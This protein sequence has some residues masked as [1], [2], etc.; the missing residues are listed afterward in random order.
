MRTEVDYSKGKK[1]IENFV[2]D[3]FRSPT[4]KEFKNLGGD[5]SYYHFYKL[6]REMGLNGRQGN[7]VTYEVL[8]KKGEVLFTGSSS[9][10]AEEFGVTIYNVSQI[11]SKNMK[12]KRKYIVRKK[13]I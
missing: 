11:C 12:L 1:I 5:L 10:I 9:E 8:N 2:Y 6:C 7:K 3:F 13:E 4:Y